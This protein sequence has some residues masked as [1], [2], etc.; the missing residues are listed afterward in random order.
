MSSSWL[1][2]LYLCHTEGQLATGVVNS[3]HF[4]GHIGEVVIRFSALFDMENART[5]VFMYRHLGEGCW[6]PARRE[7]VGV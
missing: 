1:I 3:Q 2:V 4:L 6:S 7:Q 5:M